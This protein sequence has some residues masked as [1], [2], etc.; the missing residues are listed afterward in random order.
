[1]KPIEKR[2]MRVSRMREEISAAG[3]CGGEKQKADKRERKRR[4]RRERKIQLLPLIS[5]VPIVE[6]R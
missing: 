1:M 6:V 5:S 4:G 3:L 2:W